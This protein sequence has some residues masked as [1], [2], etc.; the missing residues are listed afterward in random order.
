M[1]PVNQNRTR[2]PEIIEPKAGETFVVVAAPEDVRQGD[3]AAGVDEPAG[4]WIRGA[5][6]PPNV[7]VLR[8]SVVFFS[9]D[10]PARGRVDPGG[11]AAPARGR[12]LPLAA[13]RHDWRCR[14]C[15]RKNK[16]A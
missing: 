16:N 8:H 4:V 14:G 9:F 15:G 7:P 11:A 1:L 10:V 6:R 2:L 3:H 12:V 5:R 13:A